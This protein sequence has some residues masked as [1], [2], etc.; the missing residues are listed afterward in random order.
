MPRF[1]ARA[2]MAQNG[3]NIIWVVGTLG[4]VLWVYGVLSEPTFVGLYGASPVAGG[5]EGCVTGLDSP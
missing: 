5:G 4:A 2:Y 1:S 3:A